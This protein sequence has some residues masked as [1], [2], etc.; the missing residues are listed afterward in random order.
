M[1][2][3]D[4]K[5]IIL[6][7]NKQHDNEKNKVLITN[8]LLKIKQ[9]QLIENS[10][11]LSGTSYVHK[12]K[13]YPIASK[14]WSN[15]SYTY[16][17]NTNKFSTSQNKN[18]S[19]LIKAYFNSY[20]RKLEKNLKNIRSRNVRRFRL[21]KI[22]T[23]INGIL[24]SRAEIKHTNDKAIITVYV[25]NNQKKYYFN[26]L[27]KIFTRFQL[28]MSGPN[29]WSLNEKNKFIISKIN[30]YINWKLDKHIA[31]FGYKSL[32]VNYVRNLIFKT[33][34][35]RNINTFISKVFNKGLYLLEFPNKIT[36]DS[37]IKRFKSKNKK[38][39]SKHIKYKLNKQFNLI[40]FL[41]FRSRSN[42][43]FKG[44]KG[45]NPNLEES[46]ETRS[47]FL[48]NRKNKIIN[49][50]LEK[51]KNKVLFLKKKVN[52]QVN[53][54]SYFGTKANLVKRLFLYKTDIDN[55]HS[56]LK[57]I[58][59]SL[60]KEKFN[61]R[62]YKRELALHLNLNNSSDACRHYLFKDM[63]RK[64]NIGLNL[65]EIA[66]EKFFALLKSSEEKFIRKFS[67]KLLRREIVSL[68]LKQLLRFNSI[69][70][71]KNYVSVLADQVKK[72]YKKNVEFNF[73]SLKYPYLDS[74]IFSNI[75]V[76]KIKSN[77]KIYPFILD[78]FASMFSIRGL[79]VSD[80][81]AMYNEMYKKKWLIQNLGFNNIFSELDTI[82]K[83][84]S[85]KV[86][87]L[88][89]SVSKFTDKDLEN[90]S[91]DILKINMTNNRYRLIKV[92]KSIKYKSL[93][94]VKFQLSGRL[95]K[96][97]TA[98]R[99]MSSF[100][101]KGNIRNVDSSD[102]GL[103]TVLLNGYSKSNLQQSKLNSKVRTGSF[104]LKGWIS[105]K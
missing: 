69:K 83:F 64:S 2:Y 61:G 102:K 12:I 46:L 94:G 65:N 57:E 87:V 84:T 11:T 97:N 13:H 4:K 59:T 38:F 40:E 6:N 56:K 98:S 90:S 105:S 70:F 58:Q 99:A 72:L 28:A 5:Q 82:N 100:K 24:S 41:R 81:E 1:K 78:K 10:K 55:K 52:R 49:S 8:K 63:S 29:R 85:E 62:A 23:S 31:N 47:F 37:K 44:F 22:K 16:D 18:L 9:N 89:K 77:K 60:I 48:R 30:K 32:S 80:R 26:K 17:K 7:K 15:S 36:S 96:Y 35:F 39:K 88:D 53:S 25:Y 75:I 34:T 101:Y 92:I 33:K 71:D 45:F 20:S 86:D 91:S 104:G 67:R 74:S 19:E 79:S 3:S 51:T 21:K 103:S 27:N 50:F 95:S 76:R 14:E 66:K 68:Y 54:F 43:N 93:N 42:K 73:V